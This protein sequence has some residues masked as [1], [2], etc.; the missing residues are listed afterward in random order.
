MQTLALLGMPWIGERAREDLGDEPNPPGY[1]EDVELL[2]Y[3]FT[4]D[5]LD[6][7]GDCAGHV[8][9]IAFNGMVEPERGEQWQR[10]IAGG[11]TIIIPFRHPLESACSNRV[12]APH[13]QPFFQTTSYLFKYYR[14]YSALATLMTGPFRDLAARTVCVPYQLHLD[15]PEGFVELLRCHAGLPA[16]P[17]R[18]A[19]AIA[20][21]RP[22]LHRYR[23]EELPP[24]ALTWYER[25]PARS[26]YEA[27]CA[28][29][30]PALWAHIATLT[31]R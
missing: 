27:L 4:A 31:S 12:F 29:S 11:A 10:L 16:C 21:I 3:G 17:S 13:G 20:N 5:V 25:L 14:S 26:V 30:G 7:V 8:A 6:R 19:E 1:F 9:K 28:K 15:D 23:L 18:Q 2:S 22:E 24:E